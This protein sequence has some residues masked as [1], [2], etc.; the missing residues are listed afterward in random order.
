VIGQN[1][2]ATMALAQFGLLLRDSC[3]QYQSRTIIAIVQAAA[4]FSKG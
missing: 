4:M 1:M 2:A 3:T